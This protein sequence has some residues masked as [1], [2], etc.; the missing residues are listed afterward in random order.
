VLISFAA[1]VEQ[2]TPSGSGIL[3]IRLNMFAEGLVNEKLVE[4]KDKARKATGQ[5]R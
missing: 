5:A 1:R 3:Q 2:L 4:L